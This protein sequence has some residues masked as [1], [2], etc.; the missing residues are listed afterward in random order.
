M[1]AVR[2]LK[3]TFDDVFRD[4]KVSLKISLPFLLTIGVIFL[5]VVIAV[6]LDRQGLA[7]ESGSVLEEQL[8]DVLQKDSHWA[9]VVVAVVA[10][11]LVIATF[12]WTA[13]A[14]HRYAAL[15]E[16]PEGWFPRW[17]KG[18]ALRYFF[19]TIVIFILAAVLTVLPLGLISEVA[20]KNPDGSVTFDPF[21]LPYPLTVKN[22]ALAILFSFLIGG[23][24]LRMSIMLPALSIGRNLGLGEAWSL[25]KENG[26]LFAVYGLIAVI[27]MLGFGLT[28]FVTALVPDLGLMA[29]LNIWIQILVGIGVVTRIY[30]HVTQSPD[31]ANPTEPAAELPEPA[32]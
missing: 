15:G 19:A 5:A 11:V 4:L 18:M 25:G 26:M 24:V 20:D 10:F 12:L 8:G 31:P 23:A 1:L 17:H 21:A 14:W 27:L 16:T 2:I 28:D 9:I 7:A 30:M 3:L 6:F 32:D 13:V 29:L 22:V